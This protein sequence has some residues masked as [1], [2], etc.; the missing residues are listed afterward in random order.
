VTDIQRHRGP[1]DQGIRLFSLATGKSSELGKDRR[2]PEGHFE[3]GLGFNR[4]SILDLSEHGHQPMENADG[5]I[6]IAFNG[7][8]YNAFD[9][10][11]ELEASGFHFRSRS[12]T[13]VILYLY[14]KYGLD[15][16]L[17][18]LN[19]MFAIVIVDL[20]T[21]EILIARD[22]LGIADVL[23]DRRSTLPSPLRKS[24]LPHPAL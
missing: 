18:R 1:D 19:G 22:H 2:Q 4:L 21:R 11:A 24:F 6:F 23:D 17:S 16:M 20:R 9:Y 12:D 8:I 3:G 7:E 13:E 14:E 15:G 5:S 10:T